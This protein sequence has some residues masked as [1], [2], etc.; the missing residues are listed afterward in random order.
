M[1]R[2][3]DRKKQKGGREEK[4]KY[5]ADYNRGACNFNTSHEGKLNGVQ[6]VKYHICRKCLYDEGVEKYHPEKEC[7]KK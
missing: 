6:M 3:D 7:V 5:C 4:K 1:K 2:M